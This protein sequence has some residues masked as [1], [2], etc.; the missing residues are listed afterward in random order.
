MFLCWLNLC[1]FWLH[2]V[3]M[4]FMTTLYWAMF[5]ISLLSQLHTVCAKILEIHY[6]IMK[7]NTITVIKLNHTSLTQS[8]QL[9]PICLTVYM[10]FYALA[11]VFV[12]NILYFLPCSPL[13]GLFFRTLTFLEHDIK[14]VF[15]FDGKPPGEK[16]AVVSDTCES[17]S[18][19][20]LDTKHILLVCQTVTGQRDWSECFP[21]A[22]NGGRTAILICWLKKIS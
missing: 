20:Q 2:F 6:K 12:W 13:T 22:D 15:V 16:L 7:Y 11:S 17:V 5:L 8:Q 19:T 3:G 18:L 10:G 14:P 21:R 1:V 9:Q 4:L